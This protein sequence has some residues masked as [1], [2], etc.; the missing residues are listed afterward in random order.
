MI[1][2]HSH[3]EILVDLNEVEIREDSIEVMILLS[4]AKNESVRYHVEGWNRSANWKI[5]EWNSR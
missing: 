3:D 4:I 2:G 5:E 1:E